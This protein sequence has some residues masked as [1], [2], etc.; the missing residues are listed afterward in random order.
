M[1]CLGPQAEFSYL[2]TTHILPLGCFPLCPLSSFLRVKIISLESNNGSHA[3]SFLHLLKLH[4]L[5]FGPFCWFAV[6]LSQLVPCS[7]SCFSQASRLIWSFHSSYLLCVCWGFFTGQFST[8][9]LGSWALPVSQGHCVLFL[10]H[11]HALPYTDYS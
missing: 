2:F 9:G 6:L 10:S 4:S 1:L 11:F 8:C 5:S 7:S 3:A